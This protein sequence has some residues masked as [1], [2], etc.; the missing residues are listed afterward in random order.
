M[1]K[2]LVFKIKNN[3]YTRCKYGFKKMQN[4]LKLMT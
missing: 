4:T 3:N 2:E 1:R